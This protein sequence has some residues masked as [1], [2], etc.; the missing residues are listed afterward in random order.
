MFNYSCALSLAVCCSNIHGAYSFC[1]STE[2]SHCCLWC[3]SLPDS[4]GQPPADHSGSTRCS[5]SVP[6]RSWRGCK[7][8]R[9]HASNCLSSQHGC[10]TFCTTLA[11]QCTPAV[12][13]AAAVV[14]SSMSSS[15]E[16]SRSK[17]SSKALPAKQLYIT[18]SMY[19]HQ[20][21]RRCTPITGEGVGGAVRGMAV[22]I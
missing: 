19:D 10:S 6:V 17:I 21:C 15:R 5:D 8:P 11:A 3:P 9:Q 14:T 13:A 1:N 18:C 4:F 2:Q 20:L 12:A 22:S 7:L 16:S